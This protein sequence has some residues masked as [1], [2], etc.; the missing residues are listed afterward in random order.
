MVRRRSRRSRSSTK[1]SNLLKLG[2]GMPIRKS[3]R[4]SKSRA[5]S[6][7]P[8][9]KSRTNRRTTKSRYTKK[10]RKRSRRTRK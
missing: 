8:K 6:S 5:R 1:L 2:L 3:R 10:S 7:S 4:S 9:R